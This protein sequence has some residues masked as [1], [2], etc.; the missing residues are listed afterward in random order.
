MVFTVSGA[1]P[2]GVGAPGHTQPLAVDAGCFC[3]SLP[4]LQ[5]DNVMWEQKRLRA[6]SSAI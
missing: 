1:V 5:T 6:C 2:R 4:C 3:A